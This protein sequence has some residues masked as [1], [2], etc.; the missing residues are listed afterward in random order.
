MEEKR[1]QEE[2]RQQKKEEAE[3]ERQRMREKKEHEQVGEIEEIVR[4]SLSTKIQNVHRFYH[5]GFSVQT[6]VDNKQAFCIQPRR[7][8]RALFDDI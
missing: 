2:E 6:T 1:K 3:R 7:F 5:F 4:Q 8:L